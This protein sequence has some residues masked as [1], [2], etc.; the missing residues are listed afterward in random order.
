MPLFPWGPQPPSG[1]S[2]CLWLQGL[3][4]KVRVEAG[5][6]TRRRQARRF[7]THRVAEAGPGDPLPQPPGRLPGLELPSRS[8]GV[9]QRGV[10]VLS[11]Q[12][13]P[14]MLVLCRII[15][16][17]W[18]GSAPLEGPQL[19]DPRPCLGLGVVSVPGLVGEEGSLLGPWDPTSAKL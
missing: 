18:G 9:G 1:G 15:A 11:H 10:W 7:F 12:T 14:Q 17:E 6:L 3:P 19:A 5:E 13:F 8:F 2:T 4:N 16:T